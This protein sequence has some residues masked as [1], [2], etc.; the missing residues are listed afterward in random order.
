MASV[1]LLARWIALALLAI[2]VRGGAFAASTSCRNPTRRQEWRTLTTSQRADWLRAVK[3]LNN[4]PH[5]SKLAPSVRPSDIP[6]VNT[7]SSYWD[8]LVYIHMDLNIRIHGTGQ[9]FPWHRWYLHIIEKDMKTKCGYQGSAPY[10][11]WTKDAANFQ[12]SDFFQ[13]SSSTSGLGG[14]GDPTKDFAVPDGA[15]AGFRLSYP[16]PHTL[17][18]IFTP[19]PFLQYG[20]LVFAVDLFK[21]SDVDR[22][23]NGHTG[24]FKAFQG[25]VEA[26]IGMHSAVHV[27]VGGDLGGVCPSDAPAGCTGGPTFSANEPLFQLHHGMVD[28]IWYDWQRKHKTNKRAFLGG[29]VQPDFTNITDILLYPSGKAPMLN[30]L[31]SIPADGMYDEVT[32]GDMMDTMGDYLC[33]VYV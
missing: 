2:S 27:G 4:L 22:A 23:V 1:L 5:S 33:Y 8:D 15:L 30:L 20:S 9:F 19:Q 32:I 3:C 31:S 11:D 14:W 29:S 12:N 25:D 18:R 16:S 7:S 28:K 10:W 6:P 13:D 21:K 26:L 24:D 17:R